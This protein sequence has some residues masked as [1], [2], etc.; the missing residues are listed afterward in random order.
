LDARNLDRGPYR[1][2]FYLYR[3]YETLEDLA[4]KASIES[5]RLARYL[6]GVLL[7]VGLFLLPLRFIHV[8]PFPM[9]GD[10]LRW[11]FAASDK[12]GIR[13]PEDLEISVTLIADLIVTVFLYMGVQKLW[14]TLQAKRRAARRG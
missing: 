14:E 1:Y 11:W 12:F 2:R 6:V 3:N 7:F 5:S 4:G 8:Y 9:T 10:Q 13:D